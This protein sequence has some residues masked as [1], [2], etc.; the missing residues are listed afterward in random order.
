[1]SSPILK[2]FNAD[3]SESRP[4]GASSTDRQTSVAA[5][6]TSERLAALSGRFEPLKQIGGYGKA[7]FYLVRDR[8]ADEA[9]DGVVKLKGFTGHTESDPRLLELFRLEA[10]AAARLSHPNIIKASGP[11]E[12]QGVHFA[13]I[14]HPADATTLKDL[15]NREA[16]LDLKVAI[17]DRKSVV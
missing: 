14:E 10:R 8:R 9:A 2:N 16:W 5:D 4:T 17:A 7:A 15:L 1:M 6:T 12:I 3:L 11:E 13:V